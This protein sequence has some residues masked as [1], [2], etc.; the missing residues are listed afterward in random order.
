M[1]SIIG[2]RRSL[3]WFF[4]AIFSLFLITGCSSGGSSSGTGASTVQGNVVSFSVAFTQ[5]QEAGFSLAA[6]YKNLTLVTSAYAA[7][8]VENIQVTMLQTTTMT[9]VNGNF[10]FEGV[11]TGTHEMSFTRDGQTASTSVEVQENDL[12]SMTNVRINGHQAHVDFVTHMD[13]DSMTPG[14]GDGTPMH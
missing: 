6:I 4:I 5:P 7:S 1:N 12:V 9:D 11:P 13:M 10:S 2:R 3:G 8:T 14:G